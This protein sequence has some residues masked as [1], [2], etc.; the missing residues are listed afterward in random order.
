MELSEIVIKTLAKAGKPM[1]SSEIA[2]AAGIEKNDVDKAIK[3][4]QK[5]EKIFSPQRCFFDIKK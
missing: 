5:E 3:K 1:K 2:T 4:L